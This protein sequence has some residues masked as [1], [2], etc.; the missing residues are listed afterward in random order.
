MCPVFPSHEKGED[1]ESKE[2][3]VCRAGAG[4]EVTQGKGDTEGFPL[5]S[6]GAIFGMLEGS[7]DWNYQERTKE[8]FRVQHGWFKVGKQIWI[9]R[10]YYYMIAILVILIQEKLQ[11]LRITL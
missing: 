7:I 8:L 4:I 6:E 2:R 9:F 1:K 5:R 11:E 3:R 10:Y